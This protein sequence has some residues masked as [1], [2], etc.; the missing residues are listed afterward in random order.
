MAIDKVHLYAMHGRSFR[1]SIRVLCDVFF[2]VVF[3]AGTEYTRLFFAMTTVMP[4]SLLTPFLEPTKV[5]WTLAAH[6]LGS[7]EK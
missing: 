5:N 6:Q 3:A 2:G 1:E 7:L 4:H